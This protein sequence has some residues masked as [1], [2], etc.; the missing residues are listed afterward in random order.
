MHVP[1]SMRPC[2][3]PRLLLSLLAAAASLSL[4]APLFAQA[5]AAPQAAQPAPSAPAAMPNPRQP[6]TQ[7]PLDVD[8]DPIVSPD[9]AD[10][11]AVSPSHPNAVNEEAQKQHGV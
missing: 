2:R 10:N 9:A 6:E 5:P 1:D 4:S 8:H 7:P 11:A 3:C